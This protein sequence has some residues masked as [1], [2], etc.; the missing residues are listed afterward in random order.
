MVASIGWWCFD[1]VQVVLM[2]GLIGFNWVVM[3]LVGDWW[4]VACGWS[5]VVVVVQLACS[6]GCSLI[7]V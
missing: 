4:L 6:G 2:V 3:Q 7:G 5:V 1:L